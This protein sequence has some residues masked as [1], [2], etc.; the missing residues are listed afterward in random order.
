LSTPNEDSG[1]DLV[2]YEVR[3]RVAVVTLN[4][5]ERL[6]AWTPEL[7][8]R[9]SDCLERATADPE[10]RVVI[11]TGA[12]R[13][14]CAGADIDVI[15]ANARALAGGSETVTADPWRSMLTPK[16][17][18][19]A[20]NGPCVGLGLAFALA[21]DI[22][23]AARDAK[24]AAPFARLGLVAE[25]GTSW[26]IPRLA[27]VGNAMDI[28]LSGRTFLAQEGYEMGLINRVFDPAQLLPETLRYAADIAL[29]CAPHA[30]AAIKGQVYRHIDTDHASAMRESEEL[31][32]QA[33]AGTDVHEGMASFLERRRP[34]FRGLN[35]DPTRHGRT[36]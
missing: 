27:G 4:R 3:E 13:G 6:N 16:P 24:L 36:G 20:I 17:V 32:A 10:V 34:N 5:P 30:L 18:I 15:D 1:G 9:Y 21:C 33:L 23:F 14:F 2:L 7:G 11:L 12:G 29:N 28:L 19:A 22:R 26:A 31:T 8:A 35:S 25:D